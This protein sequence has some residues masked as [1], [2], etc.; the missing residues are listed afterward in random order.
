[1][2]VKH[3]VYLDHAC[4]VRACV[5]PCV[6]VWGGATRAG[7]IVPS[8]PLLL[9]TLTQALPAAEGALGRLLAA[10]RASGGSGCS[11]A[12]GA[13]GTLAADVSSLAS[14]VRGLRDAADELRSG[15]PA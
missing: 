11:A 1:M 13:V 15:A 4:V 10:A 8:Q 7:G 5:W 2:I 3:A 9:H 14:R 6:C 12:A